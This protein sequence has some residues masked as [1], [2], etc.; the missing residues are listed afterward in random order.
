[1]T[2]SQGSISHEDNSPAERAKRHDGLVD[3]YIRSETHVMRVQELSE[4]IRLALFGLQKEQEISGVIT[5]EQIAG[6][7]E[8]A[9]TIH[10]E[11]AQLVNVFQGRET[12]K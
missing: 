11:A 7:V 5:E 8:F 9:Y 4:V 6:L 10:L 2:T 3:R 1:M 12:Q